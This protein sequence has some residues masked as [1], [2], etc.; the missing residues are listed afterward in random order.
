MTQIPK[1]F[2][3]ILNVFTVT[4][5]KTKRLNIHCIAKRNTDED[6]EDFSLQF[7]NVINRSLRG[8]FCCCYLL[9]PL[10]ENR[11]CVKVEGS[12]SLIL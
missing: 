1:T 10:T 9:V 8:P 3:S 2:A 12:P 7:L 11:G 6:T 5:A 4:M